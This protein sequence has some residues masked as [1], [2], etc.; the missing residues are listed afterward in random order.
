MLFL[1]LDIVRSHT[2]FKI[3][4]IT[5]GEAS[6]E[7]LRTLFRDLADIEV[8]ERWIDSYA[9]ASGY[10]AEY[11]LERA[12]AV[13]NMSAELWKEGKPALYETS[14]DLILHIPPGLVRKNK[15]LKVTQIR[16]EIA[17]MFSQIFDEYPPL[18]QLVIK[19]V[20]IATRRGFYKLP[21]NILREVVNDLIAQ[22][23]EK[24]VLD[25]LIDEMV[26]LCILKIEDRDERTI[27]SD[28]N[29]GD[30]S[31]KVFSIQSPALAD[32]AMDVCTPIQVRSIATVLIE[33]LSQATSESFAVLLVVAGLHNLLDQEEEAMEYLWKMAYQ[34]FLRK[35]KD[36]L[37][38]R[39]DKWKEIFDDE[40]RYAGRGAQAILGDEFCVAVTP[41]RLITPC[42]AM[43]KLYSAPIALGPM[44]QS[45]NI[46]CRNTFFEYGLFHGGFIADFDKLQGATSSACGRYMMQMSVLESNL[47]EMGVGGP[48]DQAEAEMNF[49]MNM[50]SFIAEPAKCS[51]DVET[52][53]LFILEEFIPRVV[54]HRLQRLYKLVAK[55]KREKGT[56]DLFMGSQKAISYA[57][58]A[59]Q[60]DKSRMDS[61]QDALMI[62][63]TM[64]WKPKSVPEYL[65]L[66]HQQTVAN[67]RNATL[68]RLSDAEVAMFRHQQGVDDL[69][70]FLIVTALLQHA[71]DSGL[72]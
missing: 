5:L 30:E 27:A 40:I 70:A 54:E 67:I 68:K 44:A 60:S 20:T 61:A 1:R 33:R 63:A 12:E 24:K 25:V 66:V 29:E 14:D 32:I 48:S 2:S 45:L 49:E 35:S 15:E 28:G 55:L 50:L 4:I 26:E 57:Y 16:A 21:Y 43:L 37:R 6:K 64:N 36:W 22:G 62:L 42:I 39:V 46:I 41:R 51:A 18:C 72:C 23:V 56:P 47:R 53:A 69:E 31:D 3:P 59:L 11:F 34:G 38:H 7:E 8:E 13:R 71:S 10:C 9:E 65:P 19:I 17:M 58:E 52:K